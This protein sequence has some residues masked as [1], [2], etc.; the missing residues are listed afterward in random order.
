MLI[1]SLIMFTGASDRVIDNVSS[2]QHNSIM[3]FTIILGILFVIIGAYKIFGFKHVDKLADSIKNIDNKEK[4]EKEEIKKPKEKIIPKSN[5]PLDKESY[6]I[7]EFDIGEFK[8]NLK[9]PV[10]KINESTKTKQ[11][12]LDDVPP[13]K[14][15]AQEEKG[16]S[17]EEIEEIEYEKASLDNESIDDIFSNVEEIDEIPIVSVDSKKKNKKE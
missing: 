15:R 1:G 3:V 12:T 16:L 8:E 17:Q 11:T 2:G 5:I 4:S 9:K 7:G 14:E 6:K 10:S 13:A